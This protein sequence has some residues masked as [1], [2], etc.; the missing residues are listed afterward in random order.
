MTKS[1]IQ[2]ERFIIRKGSIAI[3]DELFHPGI[4]VIR[5]DHSV[6]KTTILELIFY[7]LGGEIKENQWLYPADKCDEVLCQLKINNRT[8]TLKR[9]IDKNK[10]CPTLIRSA[11]IDEESHEDWGS[12]SPRRNETSGRMSF[13]QKFF[14]LL[15][16]DVHKTEEYA[17]LTMHQILRLLY[18]DQETSSTRIFRAEDNP[19]ADSEGT[20][21]AIAEFLLGLD[22]L[23]THQLRQELLIAER[24]FSRVSADLSAMYRVLG[25]DSS[26]TL[27][28]LLSLIQQN[29]EEIVSLRDRPAEFINKSDDSDGKF[30]ESEYKKIIKDIEMFNNQIQHFGKTISTLEGEIVDCELFRQSLNHRRKSLLES[31]AAFENLGFVKY[32]QCPCCLKNIDTSDID[33]NSQCH[34][35]KAPLSDKDSDNISNYMEI[36]NELDFQISSNEQV[37]SDYIEQKNGLKSALDISHIN[38]K[39]S[40]SKLSQ[41]ARVVDIDNLNALARE[42]RI[43]FLESENISL[44]KKAAIIAELD[45]QKAKKIDLNADIADLKEKISA[46]SASNKKRREKVYLGM[47]ERI[48]T[49]L[50]KDKRNNGKPYEESF[51]EASPSD[52]EIDFAKDRMLVDGRVKF[53]G[54]SNFIKKNSFNISALLESME[55]DTYRL[56]RFLMVDAI[57]NGGMKPFR[58]H[59]FQKSIIEAFSGRKDFQLI[60]CTSMVLDDLDNDKFGVGP[61]YSSN[62]LDI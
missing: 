57:E 30:L 6:G 62:V 28:S 22:N 13:S 51:Q 46:A 34:L 32:S 44:E 49:I 1:I 53:S 2:I 59:N 17:N 26:Q 40:Q 25:E 27:T 7:V 60:F 48:T 50:S 12:Y 43:G 24:E 11:K 5:G 33:E 47:A 14:E 16:W 42:N 20:R 8:F 18:V 9:S 19:R 58:S 55:D 10:I 56:P 21:V 39:K 36:L 37:L 31:K 41:I 23:D 29:M 15:G 4:N 3:Y 38:L 45:N 52:I 61:F 54:S 35:C